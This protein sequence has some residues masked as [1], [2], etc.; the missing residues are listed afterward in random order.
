MN[1]LVAMI[2]ELYFSQEH[3]VLTRFVK[4]EDFLQFVLSEENTCSYNISN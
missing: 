1:C 2:T 4:K 3:L